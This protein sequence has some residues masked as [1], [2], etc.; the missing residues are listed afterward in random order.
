MKSLESS[1]VKRVK[2]GPHLFYECG[3]LSG[4][5]GVRESSDSY[6]PDAVHVNVVSYLLS[7][8]FTNFALL[9]SL[10]M[11]GNPGFISAEE[12]CT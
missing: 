6:N 11:Y 2:V 5:P 4:R 3:Y 7:A 9:L 10:G 1:E 12:T 8:S